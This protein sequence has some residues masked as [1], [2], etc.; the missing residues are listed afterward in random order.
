MYCRRFASNADRLAFII[1]VVRNVLIGMG[2]P[3][4]SSKYSNRVFDDHAKISLLVL[5]QYLKMSYEKFSETLGSMKGVMGSAGID[6]VPEQTTLRKFSA[7]LSEN[8]L[9]RVIWHTA[10]AV[11]LPDI[12][13]A[14]DSTGFSCSNASGHYVK[15]LR[16]ITGK[17]EMGYSETSVRGYS[18]TTLAVDT[19][20]L[21]ILSADVC[22]S[23]I[24]DVKRIPNIVDDLKDAGFS[25]SYVVADK[26]YDSDDVHRCIRENLRCGTMIPLRKMAE[27]ARLNCS[28][29]R[30]KA[31]GFFRGLMKLFFD[32]NIY[33]KRSMVETVNSMIK[34]NMSDVVHG[35]N[36]RMRCI[37]IIC[38]CIAH[39]VMRMI[40]F[41]VVEAD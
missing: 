21:M 28:K 39:N 9:K 23:D 30:T 2:L 22:F 41:N 29:R 20:S 5:R 12:V 33:K 25:I 35:H 8:V 3:D 14:V 24:P 15:R 37:E 38:R 32:P 6:R 7:R 4:R 26:G 16:E 34:R 13:A 11:C 27:P 19:G 10:N 1:K 31:R 40:T 18:K 17:G 36:D